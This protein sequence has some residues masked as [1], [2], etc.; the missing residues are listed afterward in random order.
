MRSAFVDLVVVGTFA[1]VQ[2]SLRSATLRVFLWFVRPRRKREERERDLQLYLHLGD[3]CGERR[4]RKRVMHVT[5]ELCFAV[6]FFRRR[7]LDSVR[8]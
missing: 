4:E 6:F 1:R 2:I 8:S 5:D 7:R 3:E